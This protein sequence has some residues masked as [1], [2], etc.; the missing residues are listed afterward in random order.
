MALWGLVGVCVIG[1]LGLGYWLWRLDQRVAGIMTAI[2]VVS[3]ELG[4]RIEGTTAGV[5]VSESIQP[6]DDYLGEEES[7]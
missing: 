6:W 1:L 4:A 3:P 2:A 5:S 7:A